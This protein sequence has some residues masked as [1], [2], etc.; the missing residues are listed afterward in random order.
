[1]VPA[2]CTPTA[3]VPPPAYQR[4]VAKRGPALHIDALT[5]VTRLPLLALCGLAVRQAR[6]RCPPVRECVFDIGIV[7]A[8]RLHAHRRCQDGDNK[9][10]SAVQIQLSFA[11]IGSQFESAATTTCSIR[12]GYATTCRKC[13][14]LS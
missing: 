3:P 6:L 13:R 5:L 12:S 8:R 14:W 7:L 11:Q 10:A 2:P 4:A 9:R 1:M